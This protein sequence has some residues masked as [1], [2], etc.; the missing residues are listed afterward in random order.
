MSSNSF[1]DSSNGTQDSHTSSAT[2]PT[3]SSPE[4]SQLAALLSPDGINEEGLNIEELLRKM[5]TTDAMAKGLESRLDGM[6]GNL[7]AL[8]KVL[9]SGGG[10]SLDAGSESSAKGND[11]GRSSKFEAGR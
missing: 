9:K 10:T 2:L 11:G 7:D 6:I 8:L 5:D 1:P 3:D 4:L